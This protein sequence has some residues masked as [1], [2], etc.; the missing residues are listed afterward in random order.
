MERLEERAILAMRPYPPVDLPEI[1]SQL[2]G[3]PILPSDT[4]WPRASDGIPLHFLAGSIV[5]SCPSRAVLCP[6]R[7]RDGLGR[8]ASDY[9]RV[10]YSATGAGREA[11]PP[12]NLPPIEG[13]HH[14]YDREMRLPDEPHTQI[15]PRWPLTFKN[16][17]SWPM[18][19]TLD[20]SSGVTPAAY[21]EAVDRA[22]A[23]EIVRTTGWPQSVAASS[24]G[25]LCVQSRGKKDSDPSPKG[26]AVRRVSTGVDHRGTYRS[27]D[28][29]AG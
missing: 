27:R 4:D 14:S 3:L 25:R 13:G 15:Y 26:L 20:P 29:A 11:S 21:R 23:A 18:V 22:R 16:I 19:R 24:V 28:G 2:G 6:H 5:P 7:R 12:T 9:A 8:S 17:K 1:C 10:L